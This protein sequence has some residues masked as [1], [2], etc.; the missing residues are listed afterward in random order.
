M[1]PFLSSCHHHSFLDMFFLHSL[2][3]TPSESYSLTFCQ[4]PPLNRSVS[5]S[6]VP[7]LIFSLHVPHRPVFI[8]SMRQNCVEMQVEVHAKFRLGL[9]FPFASPREREREERPD[10]VRHK[11][12]DSCQTHTH[13]PLHSLFPQPLV[14]SHS[15][16]HPLQFLFS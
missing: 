7:S 8:K 11:Q 15:D 2:D 13:A 6:S 10:P 9:L 1:N 16:S 14:F 3:V 12:T 4:F 5:P